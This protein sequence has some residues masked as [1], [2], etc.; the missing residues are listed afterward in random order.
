MS[1]TAWRKE[2]RRDSLNMKDIVRITRVIVY[3]GPREAVEKTIE[4]SAVPLI[5]TK[6]F[7]NVKIKSATLDFFPEKI[8]ETS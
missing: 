4:K 8:G 7:C 5:G 1:H 6:R 2:Q 3:E